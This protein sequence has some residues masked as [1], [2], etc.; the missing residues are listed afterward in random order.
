[1]LSQNLTFVAQSQKLH[2]F[3]LYSC[4]FTTIVSLVQ[5]E[6][7]LSQ[8]DFKISHKALPS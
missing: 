3:M 1:M 7:K 6:D 5:S 2:L 8:Y 4:S